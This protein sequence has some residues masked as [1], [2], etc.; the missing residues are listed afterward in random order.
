MRII[1]GSRRGK[2]LLEPQDGATRPTSDRARESIFN[3]LAHQKWVNADRPL[4]MGAR[5]LD[6]ACGTGALAAEALSRGAAF[7]LLYDNHAPALKIAAENVAVFDAAKVE[8]ADLKNLPV[9]AQ[10]FDLIFCDPPYGQGLAEAALKQLAEKGYLHE[11]SLVMVETGATEKLD[12]PEGF[13]L[14]DQRRYG[15][16]LMHFL[17]SQ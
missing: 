3:I 8:Y 7:A 15:A 14:L 2:K 17:I 9:S 12:V 5:V 13:R 1:A 11:N 10:P 6:L 16:A 4:P